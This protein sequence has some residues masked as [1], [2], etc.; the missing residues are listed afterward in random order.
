V[1]DAFLTGGEVAC[2]PAPGAGAGAGGAAASGA[3]GDEGED[4]AEGATFCAIE[5]GEGAG[6]TGVVPR[7]TGGRTLVWS[8][9]KTAATARSTTPASKAH[10]QRDITFPSRRSELCPNSARS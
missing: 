4:G 8:I 7:E 10:H 9:Q 6:A 5:A 2:C 3:A 1:A